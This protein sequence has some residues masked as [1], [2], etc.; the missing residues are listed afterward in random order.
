MRVDKAF[1]ENLPKSMQ[2][3]IKDKYPEQVK[4]LAGGMHGAMKG[5]KAKRPPSD[6]KYSPWPTKN[7][8]HW[9]H[10]LLV[11]HFGDYFHHDGGMV[12]HEVMLPGSPQ[13]WRYDHCIV[14]YRIA[15]ECN[16]FQN[17]SLLEAFKRDHAKRAY[18]LT[19]GF[20]VY[21]VTNEMIRENP[22][23]IIE[24]IRQ[25][26]SH[27]NTFSDSVSRVGYAHSLLTLAPAPDQ[28]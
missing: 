7:P 23:L 28:K 26:I 24:Q 13:K 12:A 27:R 20:V 22:K 18:A 5:K 16:G 10:Q 11:K 17:H 15:C 25:I 6:I 3:Q 19:Q 4:S 9:L 8:A 1:Y 2:Q 21:D 14:P